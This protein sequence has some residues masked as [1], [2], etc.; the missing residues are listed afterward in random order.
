[1][2]WLERG[3]TA[4]LAALRPA[5]LMRAIYQGF[6]RAGQIGADPGSDTLADTPLIWIHDGGADVYAADS[7]G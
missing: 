6:A 5:R 2:K 4:E 3:N 7:F 1:M